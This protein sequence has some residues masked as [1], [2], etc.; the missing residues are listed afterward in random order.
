MVDKFVL[1][2]VAQRMA[3]RIVTLPLAAGV[4]HAWGMLWFAAVGAIL[5]SASTVIGAV[6]A[7]LLRRLRR[8]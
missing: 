4:A 3:I 2:P 7:M 1:P 5:M 6:Q 8:N